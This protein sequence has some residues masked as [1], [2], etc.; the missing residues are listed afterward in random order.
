MQHVVVSKDYTRPRSSYLPKELPIRDREQ[1]GNSLLSELQQIW[2]NFD[3]NRDNLAIINNPSIREGEYII[4]KGAVDQTLEI[5]SLS[6]N[7]GV[8]LKLKTYNNIQE[9]SVFIPESKRMS[10]LKKLSQ[11]L[12][13]QTKAGLPKHKPLVD[14]IESISRASLKD[15]WNS[16]LELLPTEEAVWCE[17]WFALDQNNFTD[18]LLEYIFKLCEFYN[19]KYSE[20]RLFSLNALLLQLEQMAYS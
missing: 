13:E 7:G 15:V 14:K 16:Q 11:Y 5:G 8:L 12:T 3:N 19:I 17:L 18:E 20:E 2:Q 1:H 6:S 10:L 9:A 4:F